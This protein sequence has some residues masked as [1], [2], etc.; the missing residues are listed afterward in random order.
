MIITESLN[1][2][3][4]LLFSFYFVL[5]LCFSFNFFI[6]YVCCFAFFFAFAL[7]Q[8]GEYFCNSIG[9]LQSNPD[10]ATG[11]QNGKFVFH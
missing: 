6:F 4:C 7:E 1:C 5:H 11:S 9:I 8:L 3:L 2:E 10:P